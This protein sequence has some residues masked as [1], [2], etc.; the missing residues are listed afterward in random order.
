MTCTAC[1]AGKYCAGTGLAAPSGECQSGSYSSG[2]ASA[3]TCTACP[4]GTY[5]PSPGQSACTPCE[6][7]TYN[8]STGR[9]LTTD[10]VACSAGTY[11]LSAASASCDVCSAGMYC[12][13][14]ASQQCRCHINSYAPETGSSACSPCPGQAVPTTGQ[15]ECATDVAVTSSEQTLY[16]C[17][18]GIFA[19]IS[20]GS[21]CLVVVFVR[22]RHAFF[23]R[24]FHSGICA[25][26]A[27]FAPYALLKVVAVGSLKRR[28]KGSSCQLV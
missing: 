13:A 26:I 21:V 23:V 14:A 3:V 2:G 9:Q 28:H 25:Y 5:N 12:L 22:S 11:S 20:L 4:A 6:A 1:P 27:S 8:P 19:A 24:P 15:S 17:I 10:C 18:I 7:G 16:K